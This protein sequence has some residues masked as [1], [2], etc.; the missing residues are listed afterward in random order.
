VDTFDAL[1]ADLLGRAHDLVPSWLPG[2]KPRGHEWVCGDFSGAP[3][4][5]LSVNLNTGQFADFA[6]DVKGG[7]LIALYAAIHN[8]GQG[9]AAKR[10]REGLGIQRAPTIRESRKVQ[11]P[12]VPRL[13][14]PPA[15][16][17]P[18]E[19]R[20]DHLWVYRDAV[21]EPIMCIARIDARGAEKKQILQFSWD[22]DAGRWVGK[23]HPEPRPL[24]GLELLAQRPTAPVMIVEGEKAADA[25]RRLAGHIYVVVSWAGG[26]NAIHKA[27]WSALQGRR[28]LFWPDADKDHRENPKDKTSPLLPEERQPGQKSM[29]AIA[30]MVHADVREVKILDVADAPRCASGVDGWDAAD[31]EAEG[32]TWDRL[33]EWAR[34][35]AR[36]WQPPVVDTPVVTTSVVST[37]PPIQQTQTPTAKDLEAHIPQDQPEC[38]AASFASWSDLG[39]TTGKN[40]AHSN[41]E[42]VRRILEAWEPL[43]GRIWRDEFTGKLMTTWAGPEREWADCDLKRLLVL[44]QG[45]LMLPSM[46]IDAVA[47]GVDVVADQHKRN[48][49]RDWMET[50]TWDGV[51]RLEHWA[52]DLMGVT[53]SAYA[54][55]VSRCFLVSMIARVYDPGCKVDTMLILEG[56]QGARKSTALAVLGGQWFGEV[57]SEIGSQKWLEQIQGKLLVEIAELDSMGKAD[58]TRIKQALSCREDRF[59]P[60]YGR[61][62][63]SFRRQCVLVGTTNEDNYLRDATGGRR[64]WPMKVQDI[65]LDG[66]A[67]VRD[68]LFAEAVAQF[69]AGRDW[70]EVPRD[71]AMAEQD[72]RRQT[73]SWEE[74]IGEWIQRSKARE[75]TVREV[76]ERALDMEPSKH[77]RTSQ[78]RAG[79]ALRALGFSYA[80]TGWIGG[81]ARRI[82]VRAE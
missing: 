74:T 30:A 80:R 33:L 38:A 14:K 67:R 58:S 8:I 53:D 54:R 60:A 17:A 39:L 63:Q 32:W 72:A 82:F 50:L 70:W 26:T 73:D 68:Q 11:P 2:G 41:A 61:Y 59:R 66:L 69:K 42:N 21:G 56:A 51:E 46:G 81:Q 76:L 28:V 62:V 23:A 6:G 12:K 25:A 48:G 22:L 44:I 19:G 7:D 37:E 75:T 13:G 43:R 64:F 47:H 20:W 40:G 5:S 27:D 79:N 78:H 24:Y 65:D 35:R 4:R 34:P 1:A 45:K 71:A 36:V 77:D 15:G 29:R 3:G 57:A 18:V 55:A 31:A 10:L 52:V 16:T 49:P 9:E